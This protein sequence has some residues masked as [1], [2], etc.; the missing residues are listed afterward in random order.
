MHALGGNSGLFFF[1]TYSCSVTECAP[2]CAPE[3]TNLDLL[4]SVRH[5]V[6]SGVRSGADEPRFTR[7]S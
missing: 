1:L 6:R 2:E 4:G 5:G 3:L 7:Y